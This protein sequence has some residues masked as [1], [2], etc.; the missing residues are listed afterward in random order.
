V[1]RLL[2]SNLGAWRARPGGARWP[3]QPGLSRLEVGRH[4]VRGCCW[5]L[6]RPSSG[7]YAT[8]WG[9]LAA[10]RARGGGTI[11]GKLVAA[12]ADWRPHRGME[13]G[14]ARRVWT[15]A[16]ALR[17]ASLGRKPSAYVGKERNCSAATQGAHSGAPATLKLAGLARLEGKR[18]RAACRRVVTIRRRSERRV[19]GL[20]GGWD[21]VTHRRSASPA[22][23]RGGYL[24]KAG[25][26][27]GAGNDPVR[28][29]LTSRSAQNAESVP[30]SGL[31]RSDFERG[32][33][34]VHGCACR[35][36]SKPVATFGRHCGVEAWR[37]AIRIVLEILGRHP[38]FWAMGR[39][40]LSLDG[41]GGVGPGGARRAGKLV[42]LDWARVVARTN[43]GVPL[44]GRRGARRGDR[45]RGLPLLAAVMWAC[46]LA[47]RGAPTTGLT[48]GRPSELQVGGPRPG[49]ARQT[50]PIR[51]GAD[52]ALPH[53]CARGGSDSRDGG[54]SVGVAQRRRRALRS[55]CDR[56]GYGLL[57]SD[58]RAY[59][60]FWGFDRCTVL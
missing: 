53:K 9:A 28:E 55:A 29:S 51:F 49:T 59:G 10:D 21:S 60:F 40:P 14:P 3:R 2:I 34:P 54:R 18:P 38:F 58:R 23:R 42:R 41:Y 30:F 7:M 35:A 5:S 50:S 52:A 22:P 57:R 33:L 37:R 25:T 48:G 44:Q 46:S 43:C 26:G 36:Q 17:G 12:W 6:D 32:N 11:P 47:A 20:E 13:L 15:P 31:P 45:S 19:R 8:A 24:G 4:A 1:R 16:P 39:W 27:R 56:I